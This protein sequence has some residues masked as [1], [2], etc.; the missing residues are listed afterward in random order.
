MI[1]LPFIFLTD[2]V[3]IFLW[4]MT[5]TCGVWN[6][7][8]SSLWPLQIILII[9]NRTLFHMVGLTGHN[10]IPQGRS[11][12]RQLQVFNQSIHSNTLSTEMPLS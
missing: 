12:Q 2:W 5:V 9:T 8:L 3:L 4:G 1:I 10:K 6:L 7:Q 11:I